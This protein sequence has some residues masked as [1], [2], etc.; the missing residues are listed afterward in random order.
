M[1]KRKLSELKSTLSGQQTFMKGFG[2]EC[3]AVTEASFV[4]SW[5]IARAKQPYSDCEFLK[6]NIA[7]VV[8]VLDPGNKRLRQRVQELPCSRRT[9]QRRISQISTDIKVSVQSD[10]KS[11]L[12]FSLALDES[13]DIQDNPQLAIFIRYV[14]PDLTVQEEL[15]NLV[16]LGETTRGIDI[17]MLLT[18]L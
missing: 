16:T 18:K 13:T 14:S 10:I 3:D 8:A 17:K 2:K 12:A 7:D 11:S 5:N 15:L 6:K 1:R 4:M 9:T